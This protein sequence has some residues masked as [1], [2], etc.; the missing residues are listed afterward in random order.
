MEI[1]LWCDE[2]SAQPIARWFDVEWRFPPDD[3]TLHECSK[4]HGGQWVSPVHRMT[5]RKSSTVIL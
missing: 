2:G 3:Q 5:K 1:A 4:R